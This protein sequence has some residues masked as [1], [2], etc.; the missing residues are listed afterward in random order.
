MMAQA[1]LMHSIAQQ[2]LSVVDHCRD[3]MWW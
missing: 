2:N 1:A 3:F